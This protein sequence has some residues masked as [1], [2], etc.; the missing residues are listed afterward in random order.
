[1]SV[2]D[3]VNERIRAIHGQ[4]QRGD[5]SYL[6]PRSGDPMPPLPSEQRRSTPG[7][8][9]ITQKM[10]ELRAK[11]SLAN[12]NRQSHGF[13]MKMTESP[14][15]EIVYRN[16][17]RGERSSFENTVL[18]AGKFESRDASAVTGSAGAYAIPAGFY[19]Q[20]TVALKQGS[21][22]RSLANVV[23]LSTGRQL[24][25]P[26]VDDTSNAAAILGENVT[27]S[28]SQDP[29]FSRVQL[30]PLPWV[31]E[32]VL[33]PNTLV[34]DAG[35]PILDDI[36]A[37]AG[38]KIARGTDNAYAVGT[39]TGQPLGLFSAGAVATGVTSASPTALVYADVESLFFSVRPAYRATGS[40]I[41]PSNTIKN[42]LDLDA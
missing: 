32:A 28:H 36:A 18:G 33:V 1:M 37:L 30:Q 15:Y 31:A 29:V 24:S 16:M 14:E 19:R 11:D 25:W 38:D 12:S 5:L 6:A 22:I 8:L 26:V 10:A 27:V 40:W 4:S 3:A 21:P 42:I 13:A 2:N 7:G 20:L 35:I 39:G 9:T 23:K 34:N 17:M 41:M